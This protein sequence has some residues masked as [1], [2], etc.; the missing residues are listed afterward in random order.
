MPAPPIPSARIDR[1]HLGVQLSTTGVMWSELERAARVVEE[2][3]YDSVWVPDHLVAREGATVSRLEAWQ[4]LAGLVVALP[5]LAGRAP[6]PSAAGQIVCPVVI[7]R[8]AETAQARELLVAAAA[9][10]G[11]TL[12]VAGEAGVGKKTPS[13]V[14]SLIGADLRRRTGVGA[15]GKRE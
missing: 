4:A 7:G 10:R 15:E 1:L 13:E 11:Q 9:G 8:E 3:G 5:L 12:V 14:A 2:L 6:P